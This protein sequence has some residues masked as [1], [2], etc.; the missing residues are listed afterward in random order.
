MEAIPLIVPPSSAT[1]LTFW[2]AKSASLVK[3][4]PATLGTV[5]VPVGRSYVKP[6]WPVREPPSPYLNPRKEQKK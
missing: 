5:R 3:V 4:K 2:F 6:S 1:F